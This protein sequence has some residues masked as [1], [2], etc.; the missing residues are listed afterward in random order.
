MVQCMS[1]AT[2]AAVP[3]QRL[4]FSSAEPLV[5]SVNS[6]QLAASKS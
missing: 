3:F 4:T 2:V 1:V 6:R 5:E